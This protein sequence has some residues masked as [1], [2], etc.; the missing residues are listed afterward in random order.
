MLAAS[1]LNE[2]L[3]HVYPGESFVLAVRYEQDLG[4]DPFLPLSFPSLSWPSL[5]WLLRYYRWYIWL[6]YGQSSQ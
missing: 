6:R 1:R 5:S 4:A 2:Y 3:R